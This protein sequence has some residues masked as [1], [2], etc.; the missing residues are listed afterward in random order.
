VLHGLSKNFNQP[1]TAFVKPPQLPLGSNER[2][3]RTDIRYVT[4]TGLEAPVCGHAT[5]AAAKGVLSL[6]GFADV[7]LQ[8]IEFQTRTKGVIPV[9]VQDDGLLELQLPAGAAEKIPSDAR[10]RVSA[11]VRRAFKRDVDI[12]DVRFGGAA[13]PYSKPFIYISFTSFF[14]SS[15]LPLLSCGG[16][17]Q[18][19]R[20][21][22]QS[23]HRRICIR[24]L[25]CLMKKGH[26]S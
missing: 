2:V 18:R 23:R 9:K 22:S 26:F 1:M 15:P 19:R 13:F 12:I 7:G 20:R 11:A 17:D 25:N 10:D 21:F 3:V 16:G 5:L 14:V 6:P 8:Q 4:P 24:K